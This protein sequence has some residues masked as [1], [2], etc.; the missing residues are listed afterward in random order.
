MKKTSE[1]VHATDKKLAK[2]LH[3]LIILNHDRFEGY[4]QAAE[5]SKDSDLKS[6]FVKFSTQSKHFSA[7][8]ESHL[9]E[10]VE[11]PK[12]NATKDSGK[13]FRTWMDFKSNLSTNERK[14]I[15]SSCEFGEDQINKAY[16][17]VLADTTG[18]SAAVIK[19]IKDQNI[20]LKESH[21]MIKELRNKA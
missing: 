17:N 16:E 18:F 5:H 20:A 6:L 11:A 19:T 12:E 13:L 15:L 14:A 3:E 21:D 1:T 7:I 4:K 10:W 2:D 9:P 8:L